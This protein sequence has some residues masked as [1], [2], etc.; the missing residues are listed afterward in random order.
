[1]KRITIIGN[2]GSGKSTFAMKI[3]EI[4]GLPVY[5]IDKIL[6]KKNWERTPEDEFTS[7]HGSILEKTSW[8]LDGVGYH[9]T[10]EERFSA[11]DTIIFLDMSLETCKR[12]ALKRMEEDKIRP[13]P[14]VPEGCPYPIELKDK[15]MELITK[16]HIEL[17]SM[18]IEMIG[19]FKDEKEICEF[20]N[21]DQ[22]NNFL[23]DLELSASYTYNTI[24]D[25]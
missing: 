14:Y 5:H 1:M 22:V 25:P 20:I 12:Q 3:K 24:N 15:Q 10:W 17:Q 9:S 18:I 13:N 4:T 7:K 2:T 21:E 11:A 16:N 23:L 8:I 6:W 19:K